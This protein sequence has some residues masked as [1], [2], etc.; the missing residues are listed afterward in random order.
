MMCLA[1]KEGVGD[2]LLPTKREKMKHY[3]LKK[4]T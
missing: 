2:E 1:G 3:Y 4:G